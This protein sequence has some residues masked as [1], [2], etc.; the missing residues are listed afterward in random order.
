VLRVG[1]VSIK[2][3]GLVTSNVKETTHVAQLAPGA[4]LSASA[5]TTIVL[6][7]NPDASAA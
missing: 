6:R 3:E 4:I 7:N 1:F 5:V 2:L